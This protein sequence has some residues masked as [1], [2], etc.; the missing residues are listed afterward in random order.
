MT[1]APRSGELPVKH[2]PDSDAS[3][4]LSDSDSDSQSESTGPV[5][6]RAFD[7]D[8]FKA[9]AAAQR[10]ESGFTPRR[11]LRPDSDDSV[12]HRD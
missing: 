11:R 1:R 6:A 7:R 2:E 9:V 10:S 4:R 3:A 12:W 8:T 5:T